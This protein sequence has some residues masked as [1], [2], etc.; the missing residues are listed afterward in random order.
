MAVGRRNDVVVQLGFVPVPGHTI[1]DAA[2]KALAE[3]S[4]DRISNL[5]ADK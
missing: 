3:R 1:G 5:P 2:F 4:L